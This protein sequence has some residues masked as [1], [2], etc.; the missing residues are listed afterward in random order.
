[1]GR[2]VGLAVNVILGRK[3]PVSNEC[4]LD[5]KVKG[6]TVAGAKEGGG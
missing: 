5:R 4:A 1:M 2:V 6:K 3:S